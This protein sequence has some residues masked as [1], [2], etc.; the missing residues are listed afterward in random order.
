MASGERAISREDDVLWRQGG[1]LG[2]T[3]A[4]ETPIAEAGAVWRPCVGNFTNPE[5][6]RHLGSSVGA[7]TGGETGIPRVVVT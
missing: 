1:F 5:T 4:D 2:A 7:G 6:G 3:R